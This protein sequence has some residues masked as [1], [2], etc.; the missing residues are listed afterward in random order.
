MPAEAPQWRAPSS[1]QAA[2]TRDAGTRTGAAEYRAALGAWWPGFVD[3]QVK[4]ND[5]GATDFLL[6]R[7]AAEGWT[8][9]LL[10]ARAELHRARNAA[11]DMAKAA[12]FY[13]GAIAGGSTLP[14]ARRGL[15]LALLKS[16]DDDGG[17]AALAEYI[18]MK[19]DAGDRAMMAMLAGEG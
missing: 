5:F 16:G 2:A 13:R 10:Y 11:G 1:P 14:E 3:D 15:G 4:L 7:L 9:D 8:P 17:R 18:R 6:T 12:G 19:P